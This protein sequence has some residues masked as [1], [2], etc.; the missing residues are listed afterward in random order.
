MATPLWAASG[1]TGLECCFFL[2][3]MAFLL[4]LQATYWHFYWHSAPEALLRWA[5]ERGYRILR[6]ERRTFR[7]GPFFWGSSSY[8][9]VYRIEV[10]DKQGTRRRGWVRIGKY[11]WPDPNQ[12]DERWDAPTPA[13]RNV[14]EG[15]GYGNPRM[16]DR[17][18]DGS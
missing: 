18:L 7:R 4:Y 3:V 6:Q 10:Q 17:E 9:I 5:Q 11:T 12:I 16:W 14:S 8:Q 15:G 1:G 2:P 13:I